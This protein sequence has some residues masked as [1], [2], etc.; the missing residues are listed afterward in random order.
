MALRNREVFNQYRGNV[1][2]VAPTTTPITVDDVVE[3]LKLTDTDEGSLIQLYIDSVVES[4]ERTLNIALMTQ[5][6]RLTLDRFPMQNTPWWDGV[7]EAHISVIQNT[8]RSAQILLPVFPLLSVD[9]MTVEGD[10]VVVSDIWTVD[11][12][13][14][15]GRL[16]LKRGAT[17]PTINDRDANAIEIIYTAGFGATVASV[18][19]DLRHA[20]LM[21]TAYMYEHRGDGCS[22]VDALRD[23]GAM[24]TLNRYK[25]R[26]L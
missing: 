24:A 11:T 12:Q 5:T 8:S 19:A 25:V 10:P 4:F 14:R 22:A 2:T 15:K 18:P 23:S 6:W 17:L 1:R 7:V 20:L 21:C 16:V 26:D 9:S 3:H 13:Q